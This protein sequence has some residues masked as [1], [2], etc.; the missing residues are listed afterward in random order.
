MTYRLTSDQGAV[1]ENLVFMHFRREGLRPEYYITKSGAEVDFVVASEGKRER[2]LI[3]VCWDIHD[4]DTKK[5]ET[6][7]L[8]EAV[9]ELGWKKG[10]IVTWLD[11]DTS[12]E[13]I[14]I[15]PAWRWLL[16][17]GKEI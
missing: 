12:I 13:D 2:Q 4:P 11:E 15:L 3:Q 1:L 9:K 17:E 7:A 10:I 6:H 8:A 5:R 14:A 16:T